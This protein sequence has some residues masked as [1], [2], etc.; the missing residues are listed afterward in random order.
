MP[1]LSTLIMFGFVYFFALGIKTKIHNR[2]C[3]LEESAHARAKRWNKRR[4][5]HMDGGTIYP[6]STKKEAPKLL[7]WYRKSEDRG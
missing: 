6:E 3:K 1:I 7:T 4:R 2:Q 5:R